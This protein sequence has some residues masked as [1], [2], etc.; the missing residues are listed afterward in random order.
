LLSVLMLLQVR[1]RVTA[2]ELAEEL[3]V[4]E[5]T[6]YRDLEALSA[7]GV[8]VITERGP[9]GGCFLPE[10]YRTDLTGLSEAEAR[11]LFLSTVPGPLADLG[12]DRAVQAALLKL[13]AAL[14]SARR[15]DV[16]RVRQRIH[17]D[18]SQWFRPAEPVPYLPL[19]QEAVW[20][21]RTVRITY[22]RSDGAQSKRYVDPYGLVAKATIW[23]M[24]GNSV[25]RPRVYYVS[26]VQAA[27]RDIRV[28]RVSRILWAE[29]TDE[30]FERP[31]DFDLPAF[32]SKWC[33]DF[34]A[35]MRQYRVL[36]RIS[37]DFLPTLPLIFGDG[38][39]TL[40]EQA[41][42]PDEQGWLTLPLTFDSFETARATALGFGTGAE[43][44]AP[45]GL[46]DSVADMAHRVAEFYSAK[47]RG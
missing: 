16:E 9:S 1:G 18:A 6:I 42:P 38:I 35:S 37:P 8:P 17:V 39:Y 26:R 22:R 33:T 30:R 10:K 11:A 47:G 2:R 29:L 25:N 4:S 31:K 32:W 5:R 44:L 46:R 21:E 27:R 36:F 12:L 14:P 24:V 23:Y 3:E 15:Q 19:L 13:F 43:V 28:F 7:A 20:Q 41:G 40:I 34:E 45:E